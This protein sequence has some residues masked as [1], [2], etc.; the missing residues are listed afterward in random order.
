TKAAEFSP[1]FSPDGLWIAYVASDN[2]PTWGGA[3]T[4]HVIPAN[5][6]SS[7]PLAET[8]D[9]FGR[10]SE[11]VGWS[12]HGKRLFFTEAR[13]TVLRR[14][15]LPL[16]GSPE[17]LTKTDGVFNG[18]MSLNASRTVFGFGW[19]SLSTAPEAA[20]SSVDRI[21]I[22]T[23]SR[24]NADLPKTPLAKTEV[25]R[26]KAPDGLEVEGLLTY[27]VGYER[28]KRY[29]TLLVIHGGP[30]GVFTQSFTANPGLY[31]VATFAARGYAVLRPNPRGSSGYGKKFRYAN[32][33]DWGG[34]DFKDLMA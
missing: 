20:V 10:Y 4:V 1:L 23:V 13:G 12:A 32:Y 15:A 16:S 14:G 5:G 19:E 34:G 11:L 7:R 6:G 25:V 27:P 33:G 24:V 21:D 29:P 17:E 18:G 22:K 31:P 2:P 8:Y 9:H 30:M 26:W 28:G 3:A